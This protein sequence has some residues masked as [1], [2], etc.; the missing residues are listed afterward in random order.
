[1]SARLLV[2]DDCISANPKLN[3]CVKGWRR[4]EAPACDPRGLQ[5]LAAARLYSNHARRLPRGHGDGR[6]DADWLAPAWLLGPRRMRLSQHFPGALAIRGRGPRRWVRS[7]QEYDVAS[8]GAGAV[9]GIRALASEIAEDAAST[10]LIRAQGLKIR[11]VDMPFEQPLGARTAIEVYSRHARW[12]RLRRATFPAYFIPEFQNGSLPP[13]L[14]RLCS[15]TTRRKRIAHGGAILISLYSAELLWRDL[16]LGAES[17]DTARADD[18]RR[19]A[20]SDVRGC[21]P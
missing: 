14:G 1:M 15:A 10:K 8:R 5:R 4:R 12:A 17:A 9:G 16:R 20:P 7:R 21:I 2:G 13:V 19:A 11:L 18:P 6:L 3:N